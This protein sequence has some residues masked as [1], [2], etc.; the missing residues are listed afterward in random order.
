MKFVT[1]F[2]VNICNIK[3][4]FQVGMYII[5]LLI[6][7][8][9]L[10][11]NLEMITSTIVEVIYICRSVLKAVC[12]YSECAYIQQ[13]IPKAVNVRNFIISVASVFLVFLF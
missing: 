11:R 2:V 13:I 9:T 7:P 6:Y 4:T 3:S 10:E 12:I 8:G 5:F 1:I